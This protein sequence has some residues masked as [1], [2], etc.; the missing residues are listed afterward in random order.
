MAFVYSSTKFMI[1]LTDTGGKEEAA[2]MMIS[3]GDYRL[4]FRRI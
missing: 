2:I 3:A 1:A 4:K